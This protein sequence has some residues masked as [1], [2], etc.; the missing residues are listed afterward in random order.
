MASELAALAHTRTPPTRGFTFLKVIARSTREAK[1]FRQGPEP[2]SPFLDWSSTG[3]FTV[4]RPNS[5]LLNF[6]T[7]GGFEMLLISIG[8]PAAERK[9][10][11]PN[12]LPMP[13]R[14]MVEECSREFGQIGV[15]GLPFAD[16]PTNN[17]MATKPSEV[18]PMKP[19]G[20][21]VKDAPAYWSQGILWTVL[22][23][24]EQTGGS[25]SLIEGVCPLHAGPPPHTHEQDEAFLRTRR[26]DHADR[27]RQK[28]H[29]QGWLIGIYSRSL[30]SHLSC[31]GQQDPAS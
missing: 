25:Y 6:H 20:I 19:Y 29:G 21:A 22:A 14:W 11:A 30:R 26:R 3:F 8:T 5:R 12:S 18:N 1:R 4:D 28:S 13:P 15:L 9:P 17:N 16:P 24:S 23:S 27:G 10:P 7:P 2:L 31:R